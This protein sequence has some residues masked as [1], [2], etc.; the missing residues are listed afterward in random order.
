[1]PAAPHD[2]A[3]PPRTRVTPQRQAVLDAIAASEGGFTLVELYD[4]ARIARAAARSRDRL[5]HDRAPAAHGLDP[6]ARH[7]RPPHVRALP[8]RPPPPPRLHRLRPGRRDRALRS[9]HRRRAAAQARLPRRDPPGR[10]LR[11]L[12]TL[13]RMIAAATWIAVPLAALTTVSTICGGLVAV[14]ARR[15]LETLI[16]LTG[17]IVVAVALFDVLPEAFDAVGNSRSRDVA[18]RRGVPRLLPGGARARA[19][20]PRR[21]RARARAQRA[22]ARSAQPGCRRTA[23]S[24]G[25]GSASPSRSTPRRGSSSSSRSSHTTSPTA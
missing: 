19:P 5:P 16:A 7:R 18:R 14:R 24:T 11:H 10:H 8:R 9:S 23:S 25:S 1:M 13:R 21:R 4:R 2:L 17:G 12:R 20:S 3:L 15:E 22:S 6:P